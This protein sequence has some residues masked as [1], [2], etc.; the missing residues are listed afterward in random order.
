MKFQDELESGKRPKKPG[1]SFQEQ[2]EHYRD[3]LLQRVRVRVRDAMQSPAVVCSQKCPPRDNL[4]TSVLET[5]GQLGM[6]GVQWLSVTLAGERVRAAADCSV[7]NPSWGPEQVSFLPGGPTDGVSVT[8]GHREMWHRCSHEVPS[9]W[10]PREHTG[11]GTPPPCGRSLWG[12]GTLECGSHVCTEGV[13]D[14][15]PHGTVV[16]RPWAFFRDCSVLPVVREMIV[17][18]GW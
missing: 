1:Q 18:T 7:L 3:K 5:R 14:K 9:L 11:G 13:Q 8:A 16:G 6:L 2:V 10:C 12:A 17:Q 15:E 4:D